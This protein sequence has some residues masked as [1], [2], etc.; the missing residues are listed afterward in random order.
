MSLPRAPSGAERETLAA[1]AAVAGVALE[2]ARLVDAAD[3]RHAAWEEA[4]EALN[5][6]LCV[7]DR[8]GRIQ[9]ANRAFTALLD[10]PP[11]GVTGRQWT[12]VLPESWGPPLAEALARPGPTEREFL[13]GGRT[14]AATTV[15]AT[16]S[17]HG[18]L[19]FEDRT[20]RRRLQDRLLQS[21]KLSAIGQLIAGVAHDL[22]NPLTSVVGFADF[23]AES[24]DAPPR[25][26]EP[27]RVIQQEA[28]RASKIVK[29]LLSFARRQERGRWRRCARSSRRRSG[30][31]GTTSTPTG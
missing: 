18:V 1:I 21:E 11:G 14:I 23:L 25:I 28:E 13:L 4:V 8:L 7:V 26:R 20:D 19:L 30:C 31:S 6:A 10:G 22:N 3:A 15:R 17:G 5:L 16:P 29:N 27:L 12:D 24:A 9:R 2:G